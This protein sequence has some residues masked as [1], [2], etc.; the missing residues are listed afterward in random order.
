MVVSA[1][2]DTGAPVLSKNMAPI[3]VV[4]AS[5]QRPTGSS[6]RPRPLFD[7]DT[8][9]CAGPFA[10]RA[11][12]LRPRPTT[13]AQTTLSG[14]P[15]WPSTT[16]AMRAAAR[17]SFVKDAATTSE[18]KE[19]LTP[20]HST[21]DLAVLWRVDRG[22]NDEDACEG[23]RSFGRASCAD[24]DG[25]V[26][27]RAYARAGVSDGGLSETRKP[28]CS[29]A[30]NDDG[31]AQAERDTRVREVPP[32]VGHGAAPS[33]FTGDAQCEEGVFAIRLQRLEA[34]RGGARRQSWPAR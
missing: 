8:P 25:V 24:D 34:R 26:D 23:P 16:S 4:D 9:P 17:R 33:L 5:V 1:S 7:G 27:V 22:P 12:P 29:A 32:A 3:P 13:G 21:S 10:A 28:C 11:R 14:P 15:P 31:R 30:P 2:H 18:P 6:T 19:K 20:Q